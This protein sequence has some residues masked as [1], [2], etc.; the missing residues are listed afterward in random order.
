MFVM[1]F[2]QGALRGP[3]SPLDVSSVR[4]GDSF[5]SLAAALPTASFEGSVGDQT[6]L[7]EDKIPGQFN[8][9]KTWKNEKAPGTPK[10]SW[11][12]T[13]KEDNYIFKTNICIC[14]NM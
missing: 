10:V 9:K 7:H 12:S 4:G 11:C 14:Y 3:V 2:I 6:E 13:L 8:I 5:S 1:V